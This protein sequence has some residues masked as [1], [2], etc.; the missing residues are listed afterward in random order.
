MKTST[1]KGKH[2]LGK[3][4]RNLS[5]T[6]TRNCSAYL[7]W[8][9]TEENGKT[10][11]SA[12]GEVWN[13]IKTDCISCGQC[14]DDLAKLFPHDKR[15]QSIFN[16]WQAYHLND[17]NAGTPEQEEAVEQWKA[18][19]H[20]YDYTAACAMLKER[21]LLKVPV[22]PELRASALGGLPE[23][24]ETYSYGSRWLYRAIPEEVIAMVKGWMPQAHAL[25]TV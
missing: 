21:G 22:T 18:Q 12:C 7:T 8:E 1:T 5:K 24:A 4:S 23:D 13:H 19:G 20:K 14:V 17:M 3:L 25:A 15:A 16:V 11:F 6:G 9:L 2:F 10:T